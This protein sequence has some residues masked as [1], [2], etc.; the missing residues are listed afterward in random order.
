MSS[1]PNSDWERK[2]QDLETEIHQTTPINNTNI[3]DETTKNTVYRI[4]AWFDSLPPVGR[5]AVGLIAMTI[6]FSILS[7][8]FKIVTSL[9]SV[10]VV[11]IVLYLGY[12]FFMTP[13]AND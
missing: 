8:I 10:A 3:P 1:Q 2:L 4:Q 9:L 12:K 13:H 7:T 11:G 5:L 6:A